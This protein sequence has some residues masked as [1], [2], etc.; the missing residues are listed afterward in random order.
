M[1]ADV[2][3]TERKKEM[4]PGFFTLMLTQH[5][6]KHEHTYGFTDG[7]IHTD[8]VDRRWTAVIADRY[9]FKR[10][11]AGNRARSRWCHLSGQCPSAAW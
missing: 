5:E 3:P 2:V 1:D 8:T 7:E 11:I 6:V 4:T 9:S 10:T